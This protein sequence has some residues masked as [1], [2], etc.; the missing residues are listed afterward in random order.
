MC[1]G[2]AENFERLSLSSV[3]AA[4]SLLNSCAAVIYVTAEFLEEIWG[5]T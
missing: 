2:I 4:S 1:L 5:V 3:D